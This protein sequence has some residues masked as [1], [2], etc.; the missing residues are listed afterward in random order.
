VLL[1]LGHGPV[2]G[3]DAQQHG[4]YAGGSGDHGAHEALVAGHVDQGDATAVWQVQ[5][6][7]AERD[8]DPALLLFGKGVEIDA[9]EH[10]HQ[11]GLAVIDV[12]G[13]AHHQARIHAP[14]SPRA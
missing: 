7:E 13:G 1:G 5:G 6:G 10:A 11:R 14:P 4:I 3:R 8:G 2:H 9:G 12:A